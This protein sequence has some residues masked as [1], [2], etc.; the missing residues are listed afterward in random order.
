MLDFC[1]A[2]FRSRCQPGR[3]L[4]HILF[5]CRRWLLWEKMLP[6]PPLTSKASKETHATHPDRSGERKPIGN[7]V[8]VVLGSVDGGSDGI[9]LFL[10]VFSHSWS[11]STS[12]R[13]CKLHQL[14]VSSRWFSF[15]TST[16]I[17]SGLHG[18]W[19]VKQ[20]MCVCVCVCGR[21]WKLE[22]VQENCLTSTSTICRQKPARSSCWRR[23]ARLTR[24]SVIH[25]DWRS[26]TEWDRRC[27]R[28]MP[29]L[30]NGDPKYV[31]LYDW[32]PECVPH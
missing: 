17:K 5:S 28:L 27:P 20:M 31:Y 13:A 21:M 11:G 12:C 19:P 4:R 7:W 3:S 23:C 18:K 26:T 2:A 8:T 14:S 1:V 6:C 10:A 24:C 16:S 25:C 9:R 32:Y 15:T 22:P 30:R 29:L